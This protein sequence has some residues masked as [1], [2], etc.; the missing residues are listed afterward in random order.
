METPNSPFNPHN[1]AAESWWRILAQISILVLVPI[2]LIVLTMAV[3]FQ[4][5]QSPAAWESAQLARNLAAGNG[6]VTSAMRP[7][8]LSAQAT[9]NN[10]P[11]LW[12]APGQAVLQALAFYLTTPSD[13]VA[14]FTGLIIWLVSVWLT[15]IVA[16][17]WFGGRAAALAVIFYASNPVIIK[18]AMTGLPYALA[19]VFILL[20]CWLAVPRLA[21][22]AGTTPQPVAWWHLFLAGVCCALAMLTYWALGII[23]LAFAWYVAATA[24]QSRLRSIL[25]LAGGFGLLVGAWLVRNWIASQGVTWGLAGYSLLANTRSFPGESIWRTLNP[26]EAASFLVKHPLEFFSKLPNG[27]YQFIHA[28]PVTLHIVV[29]VF[30]MAALPAAMRHT[31]RRGLAMLLLAGCVLSAAVSCL[32]KP[33]GQ[34]LAVWTPLVAML[35]AARLTD[36]ITQR[37][38]PLSLRWLRL[39]P[40]SLPVQVKDRKSNNHLERLFQS[41]KLSQALAYLLITGVVCLPMASFFLFTR[42]EPNP[43]RQNMF[44]VFKTRVPTNAVVLTDQPAMVTWYTERQTIWLPQQESSLDRI[45]TL[46]GTSVVYYVTMASTTTMQPDA[47]AWWPWVASAQG[48]FRRLM[49]IGGLPGDAIL[50]WH[51]PEIT[52]IQSTANLEHLI[53]ESRKS[54]ESSDAHYQLAAEYYRLDRLREAD[55]EFRSAIRLDPQNTQALLGLWQTL[56][57]THDT[58]GIYDLAERV[59]AMEPRLPGA[60]PAL[61][62][63][64]R[65]FERVAVQS[66]D[67]W[68][69][70]N[71]AL[72]H[73]KLKNWDRAEACCRRVAAVAPKE[74]PLRLLLGDLYLQKG[75]TD[76]ALTEFRQLIEEQ[77]LNAVARKALGLALREAGQLPAAL[78]AFEKAARLRPDWPMPYF[79]AGNTCLQLKL[80]DTAATHFEMAVKL[81]P[82]TPRFS[83]ALASA[84]TMLNDQARAAKIYDALLADNPNDPVVVNNLAVAYAKSGQKIDQALT[85]I[86]RAAAAFPANPDIQDSL[87]LI[88]N[89]AGLPQEAIPALQ[90][91]IRN[92][93]QHGPA[94]YH[95]AKAFLATGR[96]AEAVAELRV[97]LG[98]E[99]SAVDKADAT[100]LLAK[101]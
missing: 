68:L 62:E 75:L 29:G 90:K 69:L 47:G 26:P 48:V 54:Q 19:T 16:R 100:A 13:R 56:S 20:A 14:A 55:A 42:N 53:L 36:W 74:L 35:A 27:I 30:F 8:A 22:N 21:T 87:G 72:C 82:H 73:T 34:L 77:P 95:L 7:A 93:P 70:L 97:A 24:T 15:F 79:M 2:G 64:A 65:F 18:L 45:E 84:Y 101:P 51:P 61:E 94:H 59:A 76:Q 57:R 96:R 63:A 10:S 3:K 85:L 99:L 88:C 91:V 25:Y 1:P 43:N 11:D 66:H 89:I 49:P 31:Y 86:R 58:T 12:S 71:A 37:V 81:A 39:K 17:R 44:E 28:A 98:L 60:V 83:F 50:R 9:L 40:E 5:L 92:V 41:R 4:G 78:E 32:L 52:P 23:I 46:A 38:G 80:Y 33:D 6:F 67:P